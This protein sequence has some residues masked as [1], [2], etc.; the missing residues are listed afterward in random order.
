MLER[1]EDKGRQVL[2]DY[3]AERD[4]PCR[5]CGFNLRGLTYERCPEC[6]EL[7]YSVLLPRTEKWYVRYQAN[8]LSGSIKITYGLA[9]IGTLFR[10][11]SKFPA[12][13][14]LWFVPF[15]FGAYV[16]DRV[17]KKYVDNVK[18]KRS[19]WWVGGS[20]LLTEVLAICIRW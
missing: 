15:A 1:D 12:V 2:R 19:M 4:E 9:S 14:F 6:G 16:V 3:L 11:L 8:A 18:S 5:T 20:L 7:A 10:L 17:C 13:Y